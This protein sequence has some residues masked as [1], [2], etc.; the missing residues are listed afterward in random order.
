MVKE[1][2]HVKPLSLNHL[3][4]IGLKLFS[5]FIPPRLFF[6]VEFLGSPAY[7]LLSGANLRQGALPP[8]PAHATYTFRS[9]MKAISTTHKTG[10]HRVGRRVLA[11]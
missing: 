11:A 2:S 1:P 6:P 5:S 7:Y 4:K 9:S 10:G 3:C 8:R